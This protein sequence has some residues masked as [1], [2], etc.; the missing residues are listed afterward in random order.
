MNLQKLK[1]RT[2]QFAAVVTTAALSAPV[3]AEDL[4]TTAG[5]E[6]GALKTGIIAFGVIVIGISIAMATIGIAKRAINKA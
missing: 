6:I 3:M 4:L 2:A 5:T 1:N